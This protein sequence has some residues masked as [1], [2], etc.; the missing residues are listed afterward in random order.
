MGSIYTVADLKMD[1]PPYVID[2]DFYATLLQLG[3]EPVT[4]TNASTQTEVVT[5]DASTQTEKKGI[6]WGYF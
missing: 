1:F 3:L 6:L 5:C 2:D 4:T